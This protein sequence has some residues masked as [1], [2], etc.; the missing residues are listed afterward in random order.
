MLAR[1]TLLCQKLGMNL[2][3]LYLKAQNAQRRL[4]YGVL[5]I[6]LLLSILSLEYAPDWGGQCWWLLLVSW[7]LLFVS[8]VSGFGAIS[9]ES[10]RLRR[11]H[12]LRAASDPSLQQV[13]THRLERDEMWMQLW[14]R[15][16]MWALIFGLLGHMI[17]A[18]ENYLHSLSDPPADECSENATI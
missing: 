6:S 2:D 12:A 7:G 9:R 15:V 11:E 1:P 3:T 5:F 4:L 17:F 16:Q 13:Y 18:G 8:I 10:N 14:S